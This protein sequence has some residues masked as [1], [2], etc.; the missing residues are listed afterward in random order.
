VEFK[1]RNDTNELTKRNRLT[2]LENEFMI[3][4]EEE[5]SGGGP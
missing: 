4:G 5:W 3:A 1:K 2:D